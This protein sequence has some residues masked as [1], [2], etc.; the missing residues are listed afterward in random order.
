MDSVLSHAPSVPICESS[1]LLRG[2]AA[3]ALE[4]LTSLHSLH[5]G[6]FSALGVSGTS[7][8]AHDVAASYVQSCHAVRPGAWA[9][10]AQ[11][12]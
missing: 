4:L 2:A 11:A 3:D 9:R 6:A 7:E 5:P 8:L 12:R 1:S 10:L